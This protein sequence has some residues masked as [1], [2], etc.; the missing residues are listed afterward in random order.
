[1]RT[2]TT[3]TLETKY[4]KIIEDVLGGKVAYFQH[5]LSVAKKADRPTYE[6]ELKRYQSAL[7]A[8]RAGKDI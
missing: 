5:L 8:F 2:Q 4:A 3:V 1:M 6:H 7:T